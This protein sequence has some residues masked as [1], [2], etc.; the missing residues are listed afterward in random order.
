MQESFERTL[1]IIPQ[2][3]MVYSES[4][5]SAFCDFMNKEMA[6]TLQLDPPSARAVSDKILPRRKVSE[7][8]Q[9]SYQRP[10]KELKE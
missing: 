7:F 6:H 1:E 10:M 8:L 9:T 4:E 2:G 3:V 5:T